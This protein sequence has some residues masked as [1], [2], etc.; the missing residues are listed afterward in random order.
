MLTR[1]GRTSTAWV[2]FRSS[3]ANDTLRKGGVPIPMCLPLSK[4][5][6]DTHI[7]GKAVLKTLVRKAS[8]EISSTLSRFVGNVDRLPKTGT[9]GSF[10]ASFECRR[11]QF[12][13]V[14]VVALRLH[15]LLVGTRFHNGRLVHVPAN[16]LVNE[17]FLFTM[18]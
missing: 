1:T 2:A 6:R 3:K 16:K 8:I 15:Q 4:R 12:P 7:F 17:C 5:T 18:S 9:S 10:L 14:C 11:L 13:Y